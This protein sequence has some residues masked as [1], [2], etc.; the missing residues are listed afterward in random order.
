MTPALLV[1]KLKLLGIKPQAGLMEVE[2]ARILKARTCNAIGLF[3][4]VP[5]TNPV[6]QEAAFE[7]LDLCAY[8]VLDEINWTEVLKLLED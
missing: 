5:N 7:L 1:S 8:E 4:T 2:Q 6:A 3:G